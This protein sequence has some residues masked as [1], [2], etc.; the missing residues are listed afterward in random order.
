MACPACLRLGT[1]PASLSRRTAKASMASMITASSGSRLQ[2]YETR[3]S[4]QRSVCLAVQS[5]HEIV[6]VVSMTVVK[7]RGVTLSRAG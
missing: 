6:V 7:Q 1:S 4:L 5:T 3:Q 2:M